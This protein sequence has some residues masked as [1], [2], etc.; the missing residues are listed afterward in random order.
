[1]KYRIT[2]IYHDCF[3]LETENA[4]FLFDYWKD[5]FT[6]Y[7]K[8]FPPLLE[9]IDTS[10]PF[11]VLV[12]HH[13]KDH[14]SRRIFFWYKRFHNI[15][16]I[17][18]EDTLKSVRYMFRDGSTYSG[19]KPPDSSI[20]VLKE[21][22]VWEDDVVKISAFGSTDVGNSYVV[23][24][25]GRN[26]FH[27]GDLNAWIWKE[28]SS[29]KEMEEALNEFFQKINAIKENFS[30]FEIAMFPVDSRLKTDYFT[31]ASIFVREFDVKLFI[32]MHFE[33]VENPQDKLSRL[34]DA[35][36]FNLYCNHE[37]GEYLALISS[38]SSFLKN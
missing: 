6:V 23:T 29:E 3:L 22:D 1:M 32:P 30:K 37:R 12:S 34:L 14:F 17:I 4:V 7:N 36:R 5:P 8:D 35:T 18:S 31:G 20:V 13:H 9:L 27:A 16:Y 21:G 25:N 38:R 28:D 19:P 11:Y 26:Y 15:R 24:T 2:Y 33:L 10:K